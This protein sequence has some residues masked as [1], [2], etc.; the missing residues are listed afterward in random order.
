MI[1]SATAGIGV[2]QFLFGAWQGGFFSISFAGALW[3][4]VAL[5]H[6]R[7]LWAE[8]GLVSPPLGLWI[9]RG[10]FLGVTLLLGA[11]ILFL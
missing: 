2:F 7:G 8:G 10:V 3:A 6:A 1:G 9:C 5:H 11:R 4:S